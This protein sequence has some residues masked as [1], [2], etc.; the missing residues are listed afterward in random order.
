MIQRYESSSRL[1]KA[2][3]ANGFVFL[4]GLVARDLDLD[5]RGQTRDVLAQIDELLA[6]VGSDKTKLVNANIWLRD[7][8]TFAEMNEEWERWVAPGAL[9]ARATVEAALANDRILV[10]IMAQ[11]VL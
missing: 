7:I 8:G 11:A 4:S 5:V 3:T 9:P 6:M 2:V 1:S 10:E